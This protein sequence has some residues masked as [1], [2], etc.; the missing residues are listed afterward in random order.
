MISNAK[1]DR[2]VYY[3]SEHNE[4][5]RNSF[6]ALLIDY[7]TVCGTWTILILKSLHTRALVKIV[8]FPKKENV[9]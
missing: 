5:T 3:A 2:P 9:H 6:L 8:S 4:R 1:L 7:Y